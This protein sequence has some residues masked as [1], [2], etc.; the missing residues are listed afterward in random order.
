MKSMRTWL[1]LAA[2]PVSALGYAPAGGGLFQLMDRDRHGTVTEEEAVEESRRWFSS[3]DKNRDG[4]VSR[5]EA[6]ARWRNPSD[7][8]VRPAD[9][10]V[11]PG[12]GEVRRDID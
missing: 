6:A 1:F 12:G 5:E 4:K 7:A 2:L 8:P 11:A 9:Q 10:G 3:A